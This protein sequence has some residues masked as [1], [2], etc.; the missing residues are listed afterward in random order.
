MKIVKMYI[1]NSDFHEVS[2]RNLC[3]IWSFGM[4][5][6]TFY[7]INKK[8]QAVINSSILNLRI[9]EHPEYLGVSNQ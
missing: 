6:Y 9:I 3:E 8:K 2:A 7:K 5:I 4:K 1:Y